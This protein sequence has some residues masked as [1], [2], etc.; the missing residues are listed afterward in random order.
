MSQPEFNVGDKAVHRA[1]GVGIVRGIVAE[2]VQGQKIEWYVLQ[3]LST[4]AQVKVPTN[5]G[6]SGVI[7]SLMG[8]KEIRRVMSILRTPG[9]IPQTSWN[10]RF[11]KFRD[12]LST[13]SV[14]DVAEVLRD[15]NS[16]R[17]Q[18][19][20]SFSE[21]HMMDKAKDMIVEEISAASSKEIPT[22]VKELDA[23]LVT[24]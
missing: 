19:D 16:L 14:A 7:R 22:V 10:R 17:S 24:H 11:T 20:L 4:G 13:G 12:K 9:D 8:P 23:I 2:E 5:Q 18:K 1:H 3:F 15:L 6:K 21:K